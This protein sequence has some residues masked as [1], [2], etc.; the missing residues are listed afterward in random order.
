MI[1]NHMPNRDWVY[2]GM[3]YKAEYNQHIVIR[4]KIDLMGMNWG[5]VDC[6]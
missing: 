2:F 5:I 3:K 6:T 4:I 1:M